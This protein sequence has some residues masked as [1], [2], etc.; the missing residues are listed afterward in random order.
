[1]PREADVEDRHRDVPEH[2][3]DPESVRAV[4]SVRQC[5][6]PR[7]ERQD[8]QR[9]IREAI[10]IGYVGQALRLKKKMQ[11]LINLMTILLGVLAVGMAVLLEVLNRQELQ[12]E[13]KYI[14]HL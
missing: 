8:L 9:A 2:S 7:K 10:E 3:K 14:L 12:R 5:P 6:Q 13:Q 11:R 1:M 4:S